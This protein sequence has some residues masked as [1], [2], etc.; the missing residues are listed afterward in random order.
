VVYAPVAN[1]AGC[2]AAAVIV[3]ATCTVISVVHKS[4][5]GGCVGSLSCAQSWVTGAST[6]SRTTCAMI[7]VVHKSGIWLVAACTTRSCH[8][9]RSS[10]WYKHSE[11]YYP[12]L[13]ACTGW[14]PAWHDAPGRKQGKWPAQLLSGSLWAARLQQLLRHNRLCGAP[15][16]VM[17]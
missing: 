12:M 11:P 10:G 6:V 3:G 1:E 8:P 4:G 17:T 9:Q 15:G 16:G 2:A 14:W 13:L 7:S 5:Y